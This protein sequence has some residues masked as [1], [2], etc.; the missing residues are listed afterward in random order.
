MP[1]F[2]IKTA[3]PDDI[4]LII[5]VQELIWEPTYRSIL[6]QEQIRYMFER[7]YSPESLREQMQAGHQFL[8]L[9]DRSDCVGFASFSEVEAGIF[10]LHK[11]YVLPSQQGQGSGT[12]LLKEVETKVREAGARQLLL[13]VN[14]YNNARHFYE[15]NGFEVLRQEDIPYGPYWLNDYVL[16]KQ[17]EQGR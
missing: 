10:K 8:L 2:A 15:K 4:P 9:Y 7:M 12:F 13:N 1:S 5:S 16:A 6:S 11:I 3:G 14:R 17:L